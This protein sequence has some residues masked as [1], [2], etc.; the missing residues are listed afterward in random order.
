MDQQRFVV[1]VDGRRVAVDAA[2]G[3][4]SL[5]DARGEEITGEGIQVAAG[6]LQGIFSM[7][8]DVTGVKNA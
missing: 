1:E 7:L 6:S 3:R 8:E 4:V 2:N 5:L